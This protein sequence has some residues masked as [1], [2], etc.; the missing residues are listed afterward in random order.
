[1]SQ[2]ELSDKEA[3]GQFGQRHLAGATR[4]MAANAEFCRRFL[5]IDQEVQAEIDAEHARRRP[6]LQ[7]YGGA[8]APNR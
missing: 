1:M 3:T 8:N 4:A 6:D 7:Q 5:V 2:T